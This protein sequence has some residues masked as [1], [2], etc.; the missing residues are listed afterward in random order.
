[1]TTRTSAHEEHL[2]LGNDDHELARLLLAACDGVTVD[3]RHI[4]NEIN[5]VFLR[6]DPGSRSNLDCVER[7]EY[8]MTAGEPGKAILALKLKGKSIL[9]SDIANALE[10][11]DLLY[12]VSREFVTMTS[13]DWRAVTR[14]LTM[15]LMALEREHQ[16]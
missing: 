11:L 3:R 6:R 8:G 7:I 9:L 10:R 14:M 12:E 2:G 13:A 16:R 5:R 1:V 4:N 15:L